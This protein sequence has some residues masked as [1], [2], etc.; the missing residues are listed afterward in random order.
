MRL[1]YIRVSTQEQLPDRQV[2]SLTAHCDDLILEKI[3]AS[4]KK[5][6]LFIKAQQRLRSGDSL[7]I[8]D[9]DRAFRNTL[10]ALSVMQRLSQR[11][12]ALE[13]LSLNIN[14]ATPE[15]ELMY[16]LTAAY[17]R[18]EWRCISRRTKEGMQAAKARGALIGRP[19]AMNASML[20]EADNLITNGM[21][22]SLAARKLGIG[23][24]TLYRYLQTCQ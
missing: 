6:P 1:G 16:T 23:Q 14:T 24:S 17:A 3:S 15:G 21:T 11:G 19:R 22:A 10:E 8:L 2:E 9:L 18:Y 20:K 12:V 4:R 5:R 7:V 13:V